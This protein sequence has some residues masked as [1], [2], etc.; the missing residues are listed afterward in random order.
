[1]AAM[2]DFI[3]ASLP[4][5]VRFGR[6]TLA[7]LGDELERIGSRR[8]LLL[9]TPE[10]AGLAAAVR[11]AAGGRIAGHF[12]GAA[13][14]TPVAVSAAA[15]AELRRLDADALVSAG[16]GST[17]G[18]GKALALRSGLPQ[19]A[20]PTTY[21]GS[22]MTPILG[23]T[24][25]GRKTT[26]RDPRLLPGTVIYDVDLTLSL[27]P[28]LSA[29]SGMNAMAHA[30]EALYAADTNPVIDL[31]AEESVRALAAGLP[32][33]IADPQDG[34]ARWQALHGAWL[35]GIC[36]GNVGMALHHKLCHVLGGSFDLPHAE[37]HC[38]V[39][40]Y[41]LACNAP[42]VPQ[43]MQRLG[44]ALDAADAAQA[45]WQLGSRLGAPRGLAALGLPESALERAA[46]IAAENPYRNPRP[47]D[48]P[49]LLALLRQ[50]HAG[51]P[52]RPM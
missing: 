4:Q 13:M 2:Q 39:L 41:A 20:V 9:T 25:E 40:P 11:D 34:A 36:L 31:M 49:L 33:V 21:A 17:T 46:D 37:T 3:Y 26:Q 51:D 24:A 19:V 6:G 50:A 8:A 52:P 15:L 30:V 14:H 35:A 22:E 45:L 28:G 23:E 12:A 42:A 5:R 44:R 27:P 16:G 10:Q 7:G 47:L 1:M 18:L 48:R 43:A 32:A 38:V 29:V